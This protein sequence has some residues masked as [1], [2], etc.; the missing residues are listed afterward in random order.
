MFCD[1]IS[2]LKSGKHL[3]R[4]SSLNSLLPFMD[5]NDILCV[6]GRNKHS[7]LSHDQRHPVILSGKTHLAR[8]IIRAEHLKLLHAGPT[9][10]YSSISHRFHLIGGMKCIK[11]IIRACAICRRY[12]AKPEQQQ[13]EQLPKER[14]TPGYVF[15]KVGVDYAGPLLIKVGS[16]RKPTVRKA[17]VCVCLYGC[18][19][20]LVTELTTE[21]FLATL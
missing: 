5:Q 20:E 10:T 3:S 17:Y 12:D 21:A 4:H 11:S 14:L 18:H 2:R 1:K 19:L 13:V 6:G 16:T 9:L 15:S 8:L 7:N